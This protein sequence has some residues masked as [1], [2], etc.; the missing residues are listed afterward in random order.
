MGPVDCLH[1]QKERG[2]AEGRRKHG[3][4]SDTVD[5]NFE[6]HRVPLV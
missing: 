4:N 2:K 3:P 6:R 1:R 5:E